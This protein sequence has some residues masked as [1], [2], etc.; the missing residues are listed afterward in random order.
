MRLSTEM[1]SD[2][3]RAWDRVDTPIRNLCC[4]DR[5]R[6]LLLRGHDLK[7]ATPPARRPFTAAAMADPVAIDALLKGRRLTIPERGGRGTGH[8][9]GTEILQGTD[10]AS[11]AKSAKFG[12][13]GP[14][15]S[16]IRWAARG[17]TVRQIPYTMPLICC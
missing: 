4:S 13:A 3:V 8:R 2:H 9:G 6:L 11:P 16:C 12:I 15:G 5:R 17:T 7:A 10:S 14:S 1:L